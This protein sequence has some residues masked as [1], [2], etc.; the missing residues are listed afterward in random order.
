[1][2]SI[3]LRQAFYVSEE[4]VAD[5]DGRGVTVKDE[6]ATSVPGFN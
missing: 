6:Q 2:E 5:T 4:Y 3:G 1:M